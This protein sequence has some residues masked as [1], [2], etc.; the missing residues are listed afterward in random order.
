MEETGENHRPVASRWQ[1]L[2]HNVVWVESNSLMVICT[3]C[4]GSYKSNYQTIT[5]TMVPSFYM[6]T[7]ISFVLSILVLPL[8]LW[9]FCLSEFLFNL[10][11]LLLITIDIVVVFVP[12]WLK[13]TKKHLS[14]SLWSTKRLHRR[15]LAI[16]SVHII[17]TFK[18][19]AKAFTTCDI[20]NYLWNVALSYTKIR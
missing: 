17:I 11:R 10:W 20:S 6:C 5:T 3:D 2:S 1:T 9:C 14:I 8:C 13:M 4:M 7:N 18:W 12:W 16:M 19:Q 15:V